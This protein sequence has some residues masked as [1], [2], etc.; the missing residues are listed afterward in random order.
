[1]KPNS[2]ALPI[3]KK[4]HP[5][6]ACAQKT[7]QV[8]FAQPIHTIRYYLIETPPPQPIPAPTPSTNP[9]CIQLDIMLKD[10]F[11]KQTSDTAFSPNAPQ[12]SVTSLNTAPRRPIHHKRSPACFH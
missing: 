7:K 8:R 4:N 11:E 12:T 6:P 1:M 9:A 3:L 2:P 10:Y 5:N